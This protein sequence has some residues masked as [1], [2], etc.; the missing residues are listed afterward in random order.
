[1]KLRPVTK[2]EGKKWQKKIDNDFMSTN[3]DVTVIFPICG[4]FGA[5]QKLDSRCM[6][7]NF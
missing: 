1:M 3:Y 5:I 6:V 2:L 7:C 4:Q